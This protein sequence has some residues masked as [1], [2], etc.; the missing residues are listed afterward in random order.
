MLN[1]LNA[2]PTQAMTDPN[3]NPD[4][5]PVYPEDDGYDT[6]KNPYSPV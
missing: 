5:Y 6:P 4:K 1:V 3:D 2:V